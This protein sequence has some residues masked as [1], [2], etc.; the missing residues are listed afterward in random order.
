HGASDRLAACGLSCWSREPFLVSEPIGGVAAS[1]SNG[2]AMQALLP[3]AW[4][5]AMEG[6]LDISLFLAATFAAAIVAG[7]AGFAFGLVA[8]AA[9]L[10]ILTPVQTAALIIGF[11]LVVQ[12]YAVWRLRHAIDLGRLLP[13]LIGAAFGVP[14]GVAT[15]K[16]ADP[17]HV[18]A[19]VGV[20][21]VLYSVYALARPTFRPIA[22]GAA[23]DAAVG[24]LNGVLG[25]MTGLAGILVTI[26][27][28]L[29]GW[30]KDE[31]RTVF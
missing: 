3:G 4:E 8:A 17:A 13:F 7:L 21:L 24:F 9:W 15:L 22:A 18:R 5:Q 12:G 27:C 26:W 31:Q 29:R 16:I 28:G 23:A 30:K 6:L 11:G 2:L 10:H 14:L 20:L 25:G 1:P 19:G